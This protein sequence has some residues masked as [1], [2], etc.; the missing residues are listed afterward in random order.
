MV[1]VGEGS[2]LKIYDLLVG[3]LLDVIERCLDDQIIH[4]ICFDDNLHPGTVGN[5]SL[6]LAGRLRSLV[7]GGRFVRLLNINFA[8][9]DS[10]T[11]SASGDES[12]R[13][14]SPS[15]RVIDTQRASTDDQIRCDLAH[16]TASIE[17]WLIDVNFAP[18]ST[19]D[20]TNGLLAAALTAQ[21]WLYL[22]LKDQD[23]SL[24]MM[25]FSHGEQTSLFCGRT[26]W[27]APNELLAAVGTVSGHVE[28]WK[29]R[30][31]FDNLGKIQV[32]DKAPPAIPAK[33]PASGSFGAH[34]G[35]IYGIS[36][37]IPG[38]GL[39]PGMTV[40]SCSDD[41]KVRAWNLADV[42]PFLSVPRHHGSED[43]QTGF[44]RALTA[45]QS[46]SA[47]YDDPTANQEYP[48][49]NLQS[50]PRNGEG[51][52]SAG[53]Q[54][55]IWNVALLE[56]SKEMLFVLSAGEDCTIHVWKVKD[57][58]AN[59]EHHLL[60]LPL[61]SIGAF[62]RH[63]GRNIWALAQKA[64]NSQWLQLATGGADGRVVLQKLP[65]QGA[66]PPAAKFIKSSCERPKFDIFNGYP[67]NMLR[68]SNFKV[69][70]SEDA[71]NLDKIMKKNETFS[72]YALLESDNFVGITRFGHVLFGKVYEP[73][74]G[75][76]RVGDKRLSLGRFA[77]ISWR[78][79]RGFCSLEGWNTVVAVPGYGAI[80]GGRSGQIHIWRMSDGRYSQLQPSSLHFD[81]IFALGAWRNDRKMHAALLTSRK[82]VT[83]LASLLFWAH[84]ELAD[85]AGSWQVRLRLPENFIV[86]ATAYIRHSDCVAIGSR[87]GE[88][89]FFRIPHP[90]DEST[91]ELP[92]W[93][94]STL[95]DRDA[96][97]CILDLGP[98]LGENHEA[99][100]TTRRDGKIQIHAFK[101]VPGTASIFVVEKF[102]EVRLLSGARWEGATIRGNDLIVWGFK[103]TEFV[104]WNYSRDM[105]I[106][107]VS[108][109]GSGRLWSF[110]CYTGETSGGCLAWM[111][112]SCCYVYRQVESSHSLLQAGLHGREIR[113]VAVR[114]N[115]G[116]AFRN[117]IATGSED[118]NI[119]IAAP[120]Q[121]DGKITKLR[122]ICTIPDHLSGVS[123]LQW[124]NDGK[125]LISAGGGEQLLVW[126]ISPV[127]VLEF[128]AVLV[129][130]CPKITASAQLRVM[131]FVLF[132]DNQAAPEMDGNR[133]WFHLAAVY[134]DSSLRVWPCR[135]IFN[136][137]LTIAGLE[138]ELRVCR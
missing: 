122:T 51:A 1:L 17:D 58:L 30:L 96:I 44:A 134:S 11:W 109:G 80:I 47:G 74:A 33:Q 123:Q 39:V 53:H 89:L 4:G 102:H 112:T 61:L 105:E 3:N 129:A 28:I 83:P 8:E 86:T 79:C 84:G 113:C 5:R 127:P 52:A 67:L 65:T 115:C 62:K 42:D 99:L 85:D 114:S 133:R 15:S 22:I 21:N 6:P 135:I 9:E 48:T 93:A 78:G 100:L 137:L 132:R 13:T 46:H 27:Y 95:S 110:F 71:F 124:S 119:R 75:E 76:E 45:N 41:R 7:W 63:T 104:V 55:R 111:Q 20:S 32:A 117:L 126:R 69:E 108:C 90:I 24:R 125:C 16:E 116:S 82:E 40:A 72:S 50:L 106:M 59:H 138:S 19:V 57:R 91:N 77:H 25:A 97:T 2:S 36:I 120:L 12:C 118:T 70:G 38:C 68:W 130:A 43:Q 131:D 10:K 92:C 107:K 87:H 98:C 31:T 101:H 64:L 29:G 136:N 81:Q 23:G 73:A 18:A 94:S 14:K 34:V 121:R 49:S 35:S 37:A 128:G 54:S 66:S 26:Y 56:V 60:E 103:G 88:L